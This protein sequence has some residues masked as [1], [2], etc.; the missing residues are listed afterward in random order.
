MGKDAYHKAEY[1]TA[2]NFLEFCL[3]G[4]STS[5]NVLFSLAYTNRNLGDYDKALNYFNTASNFLPKMILEL[6]N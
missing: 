5:F 4:D 1:K 3:K 2:K 6:H